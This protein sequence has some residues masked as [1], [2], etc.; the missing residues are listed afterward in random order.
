[1]FH[2]YCLIFF[3][4]NLYPRDSV[5]LYLSLV[6]YLLMRMLMLQW[7]Q[8]FFT[9]KVSRTEKKMEGKQCLTPWV[10]SISLIVEKDV[11]QS[12]DNSKLYPCSLIGVLT[13]IMCWLQLCIIYTVIALQRKCTL[14]SFEKNNCII[15]LEGEICTCDSHQCQ[16]RTVSKYIQIFVF[17]Q[18]LSLALGVR[19][20]GIEYRGVEG[21]WYWVCRCA[22]VR[23]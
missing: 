6:L 12:S 3:C 23:T 17:T 14:N 10:Y 22:C 7:F 5:Q 19:M 2:G 21:Q 1:M 15:L 4:Y 8:V 9:P 20:N 18:S 11:M 16:R 13:E